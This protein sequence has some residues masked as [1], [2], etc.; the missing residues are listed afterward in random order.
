MKELYHLKNATPGLMYPD[1]Y[2]GVEDADA[3]T[4]DL[5]LSS[6]A[7]GNVNLTIEQREAVSDDP[8]EDNILDYTLILTKKQRHELVRALLNT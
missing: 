8:E 6:T 7:D 1:P 3:L 2:A 4:F 5:I